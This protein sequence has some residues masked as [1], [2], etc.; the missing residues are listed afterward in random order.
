MPVVEDPN[1]TAVAGAGANEDR[2][3]AVRASDLYLWESSLRTEVF[4]EILSGTL[5]V[6]YRLLS[7]VGFIGDRQPAAIATVSGTGLA[8]SAATWGP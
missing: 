2:V 6:R 3:T 8:L 5:Q 4:T 7:Y 1:I